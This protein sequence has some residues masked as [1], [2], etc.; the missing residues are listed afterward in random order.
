M[1]AH[2]HTHTRTHTN[3]LKM[4]TEC[5]LWVNILSYSVIREKDRQ[6]DISGP[7]LHLSSHGTP[8]AATLE[9]RV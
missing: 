1:Y 7:Q 3:T 9:G 2:I 8:K 6:T 5:I 4:F